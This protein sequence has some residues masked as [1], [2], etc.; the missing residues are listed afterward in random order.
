MNK[1]IERNYLEINS[2]EE[3]KESQEPSGDYFIKYIQPADFQLNKFFYKKVGKKHHLV[4]RLEWSNEKWI[5]YVSDEKVKTYVLSAKDDLAGY[6]ELIYDEDNNEIYSQEDAL[7]YIAN[8]VEYKNT[9][10]ASCFNNGLN[11]SGFFAK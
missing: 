1:K 2:L 7:K 11:A 4:D 9:D 10:N 5:D 8:F 6:F 3:L